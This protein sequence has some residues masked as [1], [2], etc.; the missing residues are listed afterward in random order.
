MK[1]LNCFLKQPSYIFVLNDVVNIK[2]DNVIHMMEIA[3]QFV[4]S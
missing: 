2:V 1:S 4:C 3:A